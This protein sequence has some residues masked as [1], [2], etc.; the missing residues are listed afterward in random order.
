MVIKRADLEM[1]ATEKKYLLPES[2][3]PWEILNGVEILTLEEDDEL[4]WTSE[5]AREMFLDVFNV[6][7]KIK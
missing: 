2:D 7:Y 4:G 3:I 1:L 6:L 5:Y